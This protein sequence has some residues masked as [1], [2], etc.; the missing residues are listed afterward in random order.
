MIKFLRD[1]LLLLRHASKCQNPN[2]LFI[3]CEF[4]KNL[5]NHILECR[6]T[7]CKYP[8]C[9]TSREILSHYRDCGFMKCELCGQVKEMIDIENNSEVYAANVLM[10]IRDNDIVQL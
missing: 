5:W 7:A 8:L 6:V 10:S 3:E 2:C 4:A 1:R 9:I